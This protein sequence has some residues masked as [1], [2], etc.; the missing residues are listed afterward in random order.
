[1]TLFSE[2]LEEHKINI[3]LKKQDRCK[4]LIIEKEVLQD[5]HI[6]MLAAKWFSEDFYYSYINKVIS[7]ET[8][9]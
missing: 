5:D 4:I 1:M 8:M 9:S 6:I 2:Y 3:S 7:E